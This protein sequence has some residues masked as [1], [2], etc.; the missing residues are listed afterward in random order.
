M[1]A[2]GEKGGINR[3]EGEMGLC[4]KMDRPKA[5]DKATTKANNSNQVSVPVSCAGG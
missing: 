2:R 1:A 3:R 5:R 4:M